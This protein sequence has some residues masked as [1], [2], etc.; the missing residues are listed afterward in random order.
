MFYSLKYNIQSVNELSHGHPEIIGRPHA[1]FRPDPLKTV[2]GFSK[3][4]TRQTEA[5]I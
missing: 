5:Y 1:E 4:I 2:T 3:Q